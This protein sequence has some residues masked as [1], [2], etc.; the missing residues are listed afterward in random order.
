WD[1][2]ALYSRHQ[3]KASV[4]AFY[5]QIDDYLL[6]QSGFAKRNGATTR[7][8]SVTRNVDA[9]T[10]GMEADVKYRFNHNWRAEASLASVRGSNDTDGTYLAQLPPIEWRLGVYYENPNWSAGVLWRAV[11]DQKRVDP[12]KGNIAGQ[13]IGPSAGFN[14]FSVNLGWRDRKSAVEGKKGQSG[15]ARRAGSSR[16]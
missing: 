9:T 6:I 3:L 1:I 5:N 10:L 14:V 11:D 8:T 13:D 12:G 7:T 2:G 4:S 16:T 15:G